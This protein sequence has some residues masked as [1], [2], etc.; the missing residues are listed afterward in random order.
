MAGVDEAGRGALA[1]SLFASAVVFPP[2]VRLKIKPRDSKR[3]S[4]KK[5]IELAGFVKDKAYFWSVSSVGVGFIDKFGMAKAGRE[6]MKKALE[7]LSGVPEFVLVDYYKLPFWPKENQLSIKFGDNTSSSI[8]AASI[9]AKVARDEMMVDLAEKY[10]QYGFDL[11]KGYGT[12]RH[13]E[14][15]L[16]YGPCEIHRKSFIGSIVTAER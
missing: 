4:P 11:H 9:L 1:G 3:L 14:A 7:D 16:E 15:L 2:N 8:A 12:A 10:P 5:R 6:A 13:R